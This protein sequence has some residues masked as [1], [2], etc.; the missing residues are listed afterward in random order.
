VEL[1]TLLKK[2]FLK[3]FINANL[4]GF[5][6]DKETLQQSLQQQALTIQTSHEDWMVQ[7]WRQQFGKKKTAEI[8]H[9]NNQPPTISL[10]LNPAFDGQALKA[11]LK[12]QEFSIQENAPNSITLDNPTGLFNTTWAQQGAF[13]VQDLAFQKIPGLL[14][15]IKKTKVLDA[16]AA[17]GGKLFHLEWSFSSEIEQLVALEPSEKRLQ[18]LRAN[19]DTFKSKAK[20]YQMDARNI[21]LEEQ[22]DLAVV[23]A[24]C[25][26]TG[27]LR[28]HPEIKWSRQKSDFIKNQ[29]IQLAILE[30][31]SKNVTPGG[32]LLYVTCS[33]EKEENQD[34]VEIFLKQRHEEFQLIPFSADLLSPEERTQEG[35]YQ[36]FPS[37]RTMGAFA[38]LLQ[39]KK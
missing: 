28:K 23:D 36:C 20:L 4:R 11:D 26:G 27:T 19:K 22:F 2:P 29:E 14:Q 7:Q 32:H 35:Y 8:C 1:A 25:S 30:G 13:L 17:P 34:V 38:A 3:G 24:P 16:C 15:S 9:A 12:Q 31:V 39:K 18:R 33:I 37:Q 5:L 21:T 6:R 10:L